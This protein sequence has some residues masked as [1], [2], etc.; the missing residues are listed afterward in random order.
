MLAFGTYAGFP[1]NHFFNVSQKSL[2]HALPLP[3]HSNQLADQRYHFL[4]RNIAQKSVIADLLK[5]RRENMHAEPSEKFF[6]S[7]CEFFPLTAILIVLIFALK[8]HVKR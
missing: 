7:Q 8:I 4:P 5:L 1:A 6:I 3:L 2:T